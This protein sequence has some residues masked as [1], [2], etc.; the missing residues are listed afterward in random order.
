MLHIC[1]LTPGL[2]PY[3]HF[4]SS[5]PDAT[6]PPAPTPAVTAAALPVASCKTATASA[7]LRAGELLLVTRT[8]GRTLSVGAPAG[9]DIEITRAVYD[10]PAVTGCV[11]KTAKIPGTGGA[12]GTFELKKF[13][14]CLAALRYSCSQGGGLKLRARAR[15]AKGTSGAS[16]WSQEFDFAP[17]CDALAASCAWAPKAGRR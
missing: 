15:K 2:T 11:F 6:L 10:F 3:P 13:T 5:P 7:T 12:S 14:K 17:A 4:K 16:D 8:A 9:L 1:A